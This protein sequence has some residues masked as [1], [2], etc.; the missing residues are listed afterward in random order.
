[1]VLFSQPPTKSEPNYQPVAHSEYSAYSA[2]DRGYLPDHGAQSFGLRQKQPNFDAPS[3]AVLAQENSSARK[4]CIFNL[5]WGGVLCFSCFVAAVALLSSFDTF[6]G[7]K[8]V[9]TLHLTSGGAEAMLFI[10]NIILTQVLDGL[11]YVHSISLRWALLK[12]QRLSFNTNIRLFTA[13]HQHGPNKWYGNLLSAACLVLCYAATSQ[14]IVNHDPKS[15]YFN[16]TQPTGDVNIMYLNS[17]ALL[18]LAL[19]LLGNVILGVWCLLTSLKDT[20]LWSANPLATTLTAL[21]IGLLQHRPGRSMRSVTSRTVPAAPSKPSARQPSVRQAIPRL[22]WLVAFVW[23]LA[24]LAL[25]WAIT[26]FLVVRHITL[27]D[28]C[29]D[30]WLFTMT[31]SG[32][33]SECTSFND[34]LLYMDTSSSGNDIPL[35]VQLV[36]GILFVC[37]V[38][39]FQ[40]IGL[41]CI[42]LVV[43]AHRDEDAWKQ[44]ASRKAQRIKT[45]IAPPFYAAVMSWKNA[46][47]FIMKAGLHWLLGQ[48]LIP[49]FAAP[50]NDEAGMYSFHMRYARLLVY[51][52]VAFA[53]AVLITVMIYYR[54]RSLQ[55]VAWGDLQTL[56]DLVDNWAISKDGRLWW[57]DKGVLDS[58]A[59]IRHAGTSPEKENL[60]PIDMDA[61]YR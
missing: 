54:P 29:R 17:V 50:H 18:V 7:T 2:D 42:E 45:L 36:L 49:Q 23:L 14:L 35:G 26:I 16:E 51:T 31:W 3:L 37:A 10:V 22:R 60:L 44:T 57:G 6:A 13:S 56:A 55:P 5:V 20:Q 34:A 27:N 8:A 12:E 41:H 11:A 19:G 25:A 61:V 21:N 47:L 15:G 59:G 52:I 46:I 43:N 9:R 53:F 28:S 24:I 1:M 58:G 48:A 33:I 4:S 30:Q 38:Q 39:G 32:T 40:T